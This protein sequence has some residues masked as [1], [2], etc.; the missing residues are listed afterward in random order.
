MVLVQELNWVGGKG[1]GQACLLRL[2]V[3]TA[4]SVPPLGRRFSKAT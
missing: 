3:Y 4:P 1:K 2:K